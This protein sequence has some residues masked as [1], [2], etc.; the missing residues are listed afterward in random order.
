[1]DLMRGT[2]LLSQLN[3]L[4]QDLEVTYLDLAGGDKWNG[5]IA[6]P[7]TSAF[8]NEVDAAEEEETAR[9]LAARSNIP[10]EEW[11]KKFAKCHYCGKPGHIRPNC[12][13]Y[14]KK[15][16]SG[17]ITRISGNRPRYNQGRSPRGDKN[18]RPRRQDKNFLKNPKAKAF[19]SAFQALFCDESG[20][21][22]D[23]A[24]A[25]DQDNK[26]DHVDADEDLHGFLS[27]VGSSLK[28]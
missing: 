3:N 22:D 5:I 26:D 20:D 10:W 8:I 9:A 21:E 23:E 7:S 11:V 24:D 19:L 14:L 27:M 28:E 6:T 25:I 13:D 12:P 1:M 17:E 15:V 4:L 18:E 16:A 2:S